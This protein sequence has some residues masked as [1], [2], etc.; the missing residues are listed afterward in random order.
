MKKSN[1]FCQ[2]D[3][4]NWEN[5]SKKRFKQ[6]PVINFQNNNYLVS[7]KHQNINNFHN[8]QNNNINNKIIINSIYPNRSI[9]N[10]TLENNLSKNRKEFYSNKDSFSNHKKSELD[11]NILI[12]N[13]PKSKKIFNKIQK[14]IKMIKIQLTSDILK[15]KIQLLNNLGNNNINNIYNNNDFSKN[16]NN[17]RRKNKNNIVHKKNIVLNNNYNSENIIQNNNKTNNNSLKNIY[18]INNNFRINSIQ[19]NDNNNIK[20]PKSAFIKSPINFS[21]KYKKPN[22]IINMKSRVEKFVSN[23]PNYFFPKS[24]FNEN[25]NINNIYNNNDIQ[26][27]QLNILINNSI[28]NIKNNLNK[29]NVIKINNPNNNNNQNNINNNE[30]NNQNNNNQNS[31]NKQLPTGYFDDYLIN[32]N[33]LRKNKDNKIIINRNKNNILNN[34]KVK[35]ETQA[36]DEL[37]IEKFNNFFINNSKSQKD[38]RLQTENKIIDFSYFGISNNKSKNLPKNNKVIKT[39]NFSFN[40][41]KIAFENKNKEQT[42]EIKENIEKKINE[43][44]NNN[45]LPKNKT[46]TEI[47]NPFDL[48]EKS[49]ILENSSNEEDKPKKKVFFDDIKIVI[50]YS[51]NDYIRNC[52]LLYKTKMNEKEKNKDEDKCDKIPHKFISTTQLCKLLKKKNKNIKSNLKI[53]KAYNP[54]LALKKLNELIFDDEPAKNENENI[55]INNKENKE[56][57]IPKFIKKNIN[58]IKKVQECNK[59]GI[60]YRNMTLSKREIKLLNKK[61]KN[62]NNNV[63]NN[64]QNISSQKIN[65]NISKSIQ[66]NNEISEQVKMNKNKIN[67]KIEKI[68]EINNKDKLNNSFS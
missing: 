19:N 44:N 57:N 12:N 55:N 8:I 35:N 41:I 63:I 52:Y 14:E 16:K 48:E 26:R 62:I 18:Y 21:S 27:S 25:F 43:E 58:F 68:E 42:K 7:P 49:I 17:V 50:N 1:Y 5:N 46:L 13:S 39:I 37:K 33:S 28:N 9:P 24:A 31:T 66:N 61:K 20:I 10:Y 6:R 67:N 59:K 30:Q 22:N 60:N 29:K 2:T 38:A 36:K 51:Q 40:P 53:T 45:N 3:I 47:I 65:E 15:N 54:N 64:T 4:D 11:D 34:N 32:E 23:S 56:N